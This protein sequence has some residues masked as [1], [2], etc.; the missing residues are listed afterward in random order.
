MN[1]PARKDRWTQRRVWLVA[2]A[3]S[4][5]AHATVYQQ[6]ASSKRSASR[7][8]TPPPLTLSLV[9]R[10][11]APA[12]PASPPPVAAVPPPEPVTEARMPKARPRPVRK[13]RPAPPPPLEP[14]IR[15]ASPAPL[16][17]SV[18]GSAPSAA[19]SPGPAIEPPRADAAYLR[20]LPPDYPKVLL[21]RGVE[22]RVLVRARVGN[23][24]RCS[25]V[26][27]KETSGFRLFDEAALA[28]VKGWRFV[29]ARQGGQAVVAW[30]E[31]P[32]DFRIARAR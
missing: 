31:V 5:A 29:P 20:N 30:V 7:P 13:P 16:P 1:G 24:G 21:R 3:I 23:D 32:I 12:T 26:Q 10:A 15:P 22:G 14:S 2:L 27:L 9:T 4:V 17:L 19:G 8:D 6:L 28:A 11:G 18:A 25:Q